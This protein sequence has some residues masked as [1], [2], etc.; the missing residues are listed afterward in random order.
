MSDEQLW[1]SLLDESGRIRIDAV[2]RLSMASMST[3]LGEVLHGDRVATGADRDESPVDL[4]ARTYHR[5]DPWVRQVF[6]DVLLEFLSELAREPDGRWKGAAAGHLL[7]LIA[8]VFPGTPGL[9]P[10]TDLLRF[11]V[12]EERGSAEPEKL[13]V[14]VFALKCLIAL[15]HKAAPIFWLRQYHRHGA[16]ASGPV[17]RGLMLW[18]LS[19]AFAW[20][21]ENARD[22]AVMSALRA[23]LAL[24]V[25]QFGP[26]VLL[27]RLARLVSRLSDADRTALARTC[28][29]IGLG[30][31]VAA[32]T[33]ANASLARDLDD[34]GLSRLSDPEELR[35]RLAEKLRAMDVAS[36]DPKYVR[37]LLFL[38]NAFL[39]ASATRDALNR[40]L[41]TWRAPGASIS[42]VQRDDL[43]RSIEDLDRTAAE[44]DITFDLHAFAYMLRNED[45]NVITEFD[46][47][48][49]RTEI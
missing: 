12:D 4:L 14:P 43:A 39:D 40:L 27:E 48:A 25:A 17:L 16:R 22:G 46:R 41:A 30:D 8:A 1:Q 9:Q 42:D 49:S 33:D 32:A 13:A 37:A 34:A 11:I 3:W 29:A 24:L 35:E 19:S 7:L 36:D 23:A 28:K 47:I 45:R 18:D 21:E 10:A 31:P 38:A 5:L 2:N 20:L 6:Q 15:G 26:S 44:P